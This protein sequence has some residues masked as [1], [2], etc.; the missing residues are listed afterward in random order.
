MKEGPEG[1]IVESPVSPAA[2]LGKGHNSTPNFPGIGAV[3][4]VAG[5][6]GINTLKKSFTQ[7]SGIEI[8]KMPQ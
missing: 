6:A 4:V 3:N 7:I 1:S 8:K 5:L 2:H